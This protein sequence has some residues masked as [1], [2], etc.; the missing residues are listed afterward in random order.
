MLHLHPLRIAVLFV[1]TLL[2]ASPAYAGGGGWLIK[3]LG[4]ML[5]GAMLITLVLSKIQQTSILSFIA[6]GVVM[7]LAIGGYEEDYLLAHFPG[8]DAI[9]SGFQQVG[10]ALLL[11]IAGMEFDIGSITKRARLVLTNGIGQ[12]ILALLLLFLVAQALLQGESFS[13]LFYFALCLTLSSTIIIRTALD[14]RGGGDSLQGQIVMGITVLQDLVAIILLAQ[15]LGLKET[16]GVIVPGTAL[17]ILAKLVG[18]ALVLWVLSKYILDPVVKY[19][20]KSPELLFVSALGWCMGVASVCSAIGISPE[21][22]AFL[23]GVSVGILPYKL[24]IEDKVEPLKSFGMVL[25]FLTLGYGLTKVDGQVYQDDIKLAGF[26]VAL[27]VIGK[28][29]LSIIF[30]WLTKLKGRPSFMIGGYLNQCSEISLIIAL[31][32]REAKVFDDRMF[33][34]VVLTVIGSFIVSSFGHLYINEL[35][36]MIRGMLRFVDNHSAPY[37]VESFDFEFK[38]HVVVLSYNELSGEIADFYAQRGEKVLLM[39]LDPEITEFFKSKENSNIIPLYADMEDPD[40]WEQFAFDKAKLVISCLDEGQE[41]EIGISQFLKQRSPDVPFLAATSS[42][43]E[44][45]ELYEMG[46]RYVI[47]TDYLASKKFREVFG[48]E[49]DKSGSE[50]FKEKG[51]E[52]WKATR[53]IK[54]GLG[55]IFKFV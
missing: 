8:L 34:L 17:L 16:G 18:L 46:V 42:H 37:Q 39:D 38:D 54:E 3:P 6:M 50:A 25:F 7:G 23:A 33:A 1:G 47:Q 21:A 35:Y 44:A 2:L 10:I 31:I 9:V 53:E 32:A 40:V 29:I 36:G 19:L 26:F 48:E 24:D 55:E 41:A 52:H 22:G 49:I 4:L 20:T 14:T 5:G 28:P 43:E 12:I 13:T 51:E 15:L 11:F 27:V 30:G 45:L